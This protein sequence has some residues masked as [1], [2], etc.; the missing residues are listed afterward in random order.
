MLYV[1][2]QAMHAWY[3]HSTYKAKEEQEALVSALPCETLILRP[4]VLS[5]QRVPLNPISTTRRALATRILDW[6]GHA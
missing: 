4:R 5:Y 1:G 3:L 6:A 2:I